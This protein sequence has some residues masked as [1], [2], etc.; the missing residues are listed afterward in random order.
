MFQ[1]NW[2]N[3]SEWL[4]LVFRL[5]RKR[6]AYFTFFIF[7]VSSEI[8]HTALPHFVCRI[9]ITDFTLWRACDFS[10]SLAANIQT[11]RALESLSTASS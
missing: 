5:I 10:P 11:E 1:F 3:G 8:S 9:K 2:D 6:N 7:S 4:L